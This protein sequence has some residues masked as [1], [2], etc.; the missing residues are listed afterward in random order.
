M[1]KRIPEIDAVR[2]LALAGLPIVNLGLTVGKRH[3][4]VPGPVASLIYHDLFLHRFVTIFCFLFG[5]SFALVL[6]GAA[7]R[8]RRPRAVLVRRLVALFAFGLFQLFAL[9]QNLQLLIYATLGVVVLLPVSYLPRRA[10]VAVGAGLL[11]ASLPIVEHGAGEAVKILA[12]TSGLLILGAAVVAYEIHTD[13]PQRGKEIRTIFLAATI[14]AV[15]TNAINPDDTTIFDAIVDELAMLSTSVAY[16][17][18]LLLLLRTRARRPLLA[19]LSP[20]GRMALTNF[21]VQAAAAVAFAA[22]FNIRGANFA[23]VTYGFTTLFVATQAILCTLWLRPFRY[24]PAEWLWRCAT[25]LTV[26]PLRRVP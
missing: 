2:G 13:L 5:V 15:V 26:V 14:L 3:Y 7:E 9:D 4:P 16:V 23:V 12:I 22:T 21:L 11:L 1:G 8:V 25:W 6:R 24:G 18:G 19:A 17:T 10:M 20:L